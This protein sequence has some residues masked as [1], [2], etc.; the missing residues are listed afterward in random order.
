MRFL[1][2]TANNSHIP[3]YVLSRLTSHFGP[4]SSNSNANEAKKFKSAPKT[5][6]LDPAFPPSKEDFK[7]EKRLSSGAYGSVF[8]ARHI[9]SNEQVAIKVLKKKDVVAKNMINQ[10]THERDIM[11]F[12]Q[13]PF[14]VNLICS[15]SS[16][17]CSKSFSRALFPCSILGSLVHRDGVCAWW[18]PRLPLKKRWTA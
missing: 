8:L 16:K 14:L 9:K 15:F 1:Q 10:V 13:N 4:A 12:A 7:I 3:Q 5:S 11:Q 18:G 17:V 6:F 2:L